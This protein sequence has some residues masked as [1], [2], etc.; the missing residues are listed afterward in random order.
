MQID[1]KKKT[2]IIKLRINTGPRYYFGK[3]NFSANPY[4]L[5]FLSRFINFK[6]HEPFS[7][8]KLLKLQQSLST[9]RFFQQ[10][11]IAP[12]LGKVQNFEVPVQVDITVPRLQKYKIGIGYG[13]FTGP[14]VTLG[15]DFRR[16]S[17]NGQHLTV[18]TQLSSV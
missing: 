17:D 18:E 11:S 8:D 9:S 6:E 10:V 2:A 3:V 4:S 5:H 14:R 15:A 13:T 12:E 1:L 7:S 16:I